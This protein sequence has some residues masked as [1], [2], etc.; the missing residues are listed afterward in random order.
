MVLAGGDVHRG[1]TVASGFLACVNAGWSNTSKNTFILYISVYTVYIL[2]ILYIAL[3]IVTKM[4]GLIPARTPLILSNVV[5]IVLYIVTTLVF[6]IPARTLIISVI[7]RR[8][9]GITRHASH[10]T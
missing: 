6:R 9:E 3:Y 1:P 2:C 4:V 8:C 7:H 5:S 10:N